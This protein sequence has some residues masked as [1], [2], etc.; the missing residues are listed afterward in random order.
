MD[1][2]EPTQRRGARVEGQRSPGAPLRDLRLWD[3]RSAS[4]AA[5]PDVLESQMDSPRSGG[6]RRRP[7]LGHSED[8]CPSCDCDAAGSSDLRARGIV[9]QSPRDPGLS[10][11]CRR[12]RHDRRVVPGGTQF[13]GR[14]GRARSLGGA[15]RHRSRGDHGRLLLLPVCVRPRGSPAAAAQRFGPTR[16]DRWA[17]AFEALPRFSGAS[18]RTCSSRPEWL[19]NGRQVGRISLAEAMQGD[20]IV[21]EGAAEPG[22]R[23]HS[24]GRVSGSG[25]R[26]A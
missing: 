21:I 14:R 7:A 17:T 25:L 9:G 15:P 3:R 11:G 24:L 18:R 8:P 1:A 5:V 12:R 6:A 13:A 26:P 10:G 22:P 23:V 4:T 20:L 16:C 19:A 2:V